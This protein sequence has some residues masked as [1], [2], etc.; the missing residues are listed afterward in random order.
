MTQ[1]ET[2]TNINYNDEEKIATV[3]TENKALI[4]KMDRLLLE[5][6]DQ[7]QLTI[8]NEDGKGYSIPKKWV[9]IRPPKK[10]SE[11]NRQKAAERARAMQAK[12][13][14]K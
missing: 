10:M 13:K 8:E 4:R 2:E 11:E 9:K 14:L 5:Y 12:K 1:Y 7:I 3:Y 6:A